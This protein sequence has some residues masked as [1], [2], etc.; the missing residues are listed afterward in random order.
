MQNLRDKLLK[1]GLVTAEQAEKA[2]T[3]PAR[4][5]EAKRAR[6][7]RPSGSEGRP[8]T[9]G[10]GPWITARLKPLGAVPKLPPL[11]GSKASQR[12]EAKRQLERDR[13]LRERVTAAQVAVEPGEQTFYF[14]TRK[15]RL[16]RLELSLEQAAALEQGRLAV[17]ERPNPA[18]IDHALVPAPLAA[19]LLTDFPKA[20]RFLNAPG[21]SVGFLSDEE[22]RSRAA[23]EAAETPEERAAADAPESAEERAEEEARAEGPEDAE[24]PGEAAPEPT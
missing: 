4:A 6:P 3:E 9:T 13:Q 24:A 16:R 12:L 1:A 11:A 19:E 23:A 14:V 5:A 18:Q 8:A 7:E 20:V 10:N 22:V 15:N 2:A 21:A 17:V